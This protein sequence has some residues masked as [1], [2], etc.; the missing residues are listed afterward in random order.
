MPTAVN[1]RLSRCLR[2]VLRIGAKVAASTICVSCGV[3]VSQTPLEHAHDL[4]PEKCG[5]VTPELTA[6][7]ISRS[8]MESVSPDYVHVVTG[9][10]SV[11]LKG[12]IIHVSATS[13]TTAEMLERAIECHQARVTLGEAPPPDDP[14]V[15]P[16]HWT[17]VSVSSDGGAFAV[18]VEGDDFAQAKAILDRAQRYVHA[19]PP[20]ATR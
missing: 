18:S 1:E 6:F 14:Y 17:N 2:A 9:N 4:V 11:R 10:E 8:S 16:G 19:A 5:N 20:P 3:L 13:G 7:V 12:A 15:L